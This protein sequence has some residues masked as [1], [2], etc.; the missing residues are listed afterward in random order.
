MLERL[1]PG[2]VQEVGHGDAAIGIPGSSRAHVK[3]SG[4]SFRQDFAAIGEAKFDFLSGLNRGGKN[5]GH[6]VIAAAQTWQQVTA[7]AAPSCTYYNP[8]GNSAYNDYFGDY[9]SDD[10]YSSGDDYWG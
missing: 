9:Y 3:Q 7:P 4:S 1:K 10:Y 6:E 8:P 2:R 5:D